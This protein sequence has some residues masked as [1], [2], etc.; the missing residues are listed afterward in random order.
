MVIGGIE[1]V[2]GDKLGGNRWHWVVTGGSG[3]GRKIKYF[4]ADTHT[5]AHTSCHTTTL[6]GS[7]V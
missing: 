2:T 7:A 3:V 1:V 5:H 4:L 6:T